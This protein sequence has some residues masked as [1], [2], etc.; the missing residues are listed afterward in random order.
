M[1]YYGF[2]YC[3]INLKNGMKYIGSHHGK[4]DDGYIGSGV[5]FRRSYDKCP[6]DFKR[7][8]LEYNTY[9][10][11]PYITYAL[12]QKY[13]DKVENI[14]LNEQYYN[15]TPN[16]FA[17]GGWSR[18]KSLSEEHKK[19]IG[20][21]NKGK[22]RS[23]E[24]VQK[25]KKILQSLELTPWNKGVPGKQVH[26]EES[27]KKIGMSSSL[28]HKSKDMTETYKKI[29]ESKKGKTKETDIGRLTTSKKMI[30][31]KN[32]AGRKNT[33]KGKI[34]INKDGISKMICKQDLDYYKDWN[35]GRK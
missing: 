34:W 9:G 10:N 19:N 22:V 6:S 12:E 16:A 14:H 1:E 23:L 30:G 11:D 7:E 32:G 25:L 29:S 31:N 13:L 8:I 5:Y 35:K 18:G 26:S 24:Q 2:V 28:R 15:L 4:E 21:S 3:W 17:P 27:K 33:P 20:K